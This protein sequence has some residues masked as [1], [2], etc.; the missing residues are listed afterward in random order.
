MTL[1]WEIGSQQRRL[2]TLV[3][4]ALIAAV[5][6]RHAILATLAVP[7]LWLLA[8]PYLRG[9][10]RESTTPVVTTTTVAPDSCLEG[11]VVQVEFWFEAAVGLDQLELELLPDS[12]AEFV[13]CLPVLTFFGVRAPV[14]AAWSMKVGRWGRRSAGTIA[15]RAF[16]SGRLFEARASLSL[17]EIRVYPHHPPLR[18]LRVPYWLPDRMGDHVSRSAGE[19][20]EF[21]DVREYRHGDKARRINWRATAR[22]GSLQVN[23]TAAEHACDVVVL[24]DA[25]SDVGGP[26]HS[27]LDVGV[28]GAVATA[29]AYLGRHD[30]VGLVVLG[31]ELAWLRPD[32]GSRQFYRVIERILD[33]R[34]AR[35]GDRPALSGLPPRVLPPGGLAFVFSPLLDPRAISAIH[36]LRE[37]GVVPVVI[38]VRTAEPLAERAIANSDLALRLWRIDHDVELR[39]LRRSGV[40]VVEWDGEQSLDLAFTLLPDRMRSA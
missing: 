22:R 16:S 35:V 20:V 17:P 27:S 3:V 8:W 18:A 13:D 28:R 10:D 21:I 5:S 39:G 15:V 4:I 33:V 34:Q 1:Q 29:Q 30:R 7:P 9:D 6:L 37:R 38:D 24:I 26:A 11:D 31:G 14:R 12:R 19:G 36:A 32:V 2:L 25:F 40:L 23:A